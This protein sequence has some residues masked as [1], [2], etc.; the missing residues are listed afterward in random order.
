MICIAQE[1][2]I[3]KLPEG[4]PDT[5]HTL[6]ENQMFVLVL[7]AFIYCEETLPNITNTNSLLGFQQPQGKLIKGK[8]M[9][10]Y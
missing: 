2:E 10:G 6:K 4:R 9:R 3:N 7:H 8:L 1:A 5:H